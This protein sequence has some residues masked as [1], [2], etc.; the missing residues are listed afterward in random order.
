MWERIEDK[1]QKDNY[2]Q[3]R[4]CVIIKNGILYSLLVKEMVRVI[5]MNQFECNYTQMRYK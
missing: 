2:K 5:C 4:Y 3:Y 1:V